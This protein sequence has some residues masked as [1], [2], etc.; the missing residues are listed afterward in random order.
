[1]NNVNVLVDEIRLNRDRLTI[2]GGY[3][4][5][6]NAIGMAECMK[7]AEVPSSELVWRAG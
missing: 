1:M 3:D 7:L 5:V 2:R 4:R 6:A